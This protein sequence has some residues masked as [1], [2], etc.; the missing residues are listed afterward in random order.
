MSGHARSTWEWSR[1]V[2]G[3]LP[4][5]CREDTEGDKEGRRESQGGGGER[6]GPL[7]G[8]EKNATPAHHIR[9]IAVDCDS[10]L[11]G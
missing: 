11:P 9:D 2:G 5:V 7:N 6:V 3:R 8:P 1:W 10:L 4:F